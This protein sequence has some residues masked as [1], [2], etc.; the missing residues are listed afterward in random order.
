[1]NATEVL[2]TGV[3]AGLALALLVLL[4]R[5]RRERGRVA[6]LRRELDALAGGAPETRANGRLDDA[7]GLGRSLE[8]LKEAL[9]EERRAWDRQRAERDL[10]LAHVSDA[11]ALLDGDD[12]ILDA[13]RAFADLFG[14]GVAPAPG[15][16][17][18]EALR[19]PE[20]LDLVREARASASPVDRELRLRG[21][22]TRVVEARGTRVT[23]AGPGTV[24]LVLR[25]LTERERQV[26]IR[27]D[28]VANVSHEL[29][30]PLTS[31]RG[32][33]ET[34]LDGGLEDESNRARFVGVIRE[35]ATRLQAL[36]EDLLSLAELERPGLEL[37]LSRFDLRLLAQAQI[38]AFRDR[39]EVR[40]LELKLE[41][42]P[43]AEVLADRG[44][45]EQV[46][47]N[48]LDNAIKY[49]ERGGV[50]LSVGA[51]ARRAW[52]L[53]EDTGVGISP[54]EQPRIF[55][56]FYRVDKARSSE[57]GG[58]GLGLAIVKHI[59]AQH[60]GE[61]SVESEPGRGSRFRFELP[62]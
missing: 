23:T 55:E 47:A 16:S 27:Q 34:L 4:W 17:L 29:R 14:R 57:M 42:G 52:C 59:L 54:G 18:S 5:R 20:V 26:R 19:S 36:V 45:I 46:L 31:I 40:N 38:A 22:E 9:V 35:Q 37:K 15:S 43:P 32:Y 11:V 39:A 48:L 21:L 60:R 30:T 28:F 53:V 49:T 12:R 8:R 10:L 44:R 61:I 58:T 2:L 3:A 13:N 50:R 6:A 25:D 1:V 7:A 56:R 41:G 33:A 24:L 51:D 62:R